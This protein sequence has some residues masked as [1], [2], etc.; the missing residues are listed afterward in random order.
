MKKIINLL[1]LL[2]GVGSVIA[3]VLTAAHFSPEFGGSL[4]LCGEGAGSCAEVS[5]LPYA[6]FLGIPLA[7]YGLLFY[8]VILFTLLVADTAGGRYVRES[9][10]LLLPIAALAL[11]VDAG[12]GVTL[13]VLRKLCFYCLAT[14]AVNIA[15]FILLVVLFR[16]TREVDG[17]SYRATFRGIFTTPLKESDRRAVYALYVICVALIF[18]SVFSL[19]YVFGSKSR[20]AERDI[21]AY[22]DDFY[23]A[24][25]EALDL[26]ESVLAVGG[27]DAP[28]TVYVFTDF[29]C[30]ACYKLYEEEEL[31]MKRFDNRVRFVH[32]NYPLDK[33]CNESMKRTAYENSCLASR[34]MLAAF[35][36]GVFPQYYER[37]YA[38]YKEY[39]H[40]FSPVDVTTNIDGLVDPARFEG[41]M[42]SPETAGV[43][44]RDVRLAR[45]LGINGTPT[46]FINGRRLGGVLPIEIMEKI[47][48]R[49]LS[50]PRGEG[51]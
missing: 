41:Y 6:L 21:Q 18:F 45:E 50:S 40:K 22:I 26:P 28:L 32:Y 29:L 11:V 30:S 2:S 33:A 8:L 49:E 10:A 4:P 23:S 9:A 14:Y 25:P 47:I 20:E 37:H 43:I 35:D 12:L 44:E 19:C 17:V 48:A 27:P 38:R 36:A 7:A 15:L 16:R 3:V 42:E 13:I 39:G 5:E 31:L 24:E 34:S 46:L 51:E 1:L